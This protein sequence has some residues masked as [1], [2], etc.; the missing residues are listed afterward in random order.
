MTPWVKRTEFTAYMVTV[1]SVAAAAQ[2]SGAARSAMFVLDND[3]IA[4]RGAGRP[5]DYDY[6]QGSTMALSWAGAPQRVRQFAGGL[7]GCATAGARRVACVASGLA[8]RQQIYTPRR[9]AATPVPGER[10]YAGWLSASAV[11]HRVA[12][13]RI[14]SLEAEVGVSGPPSLAE[15]VQ[16]GVHR[17]LR[18]EAQ[19]GWAHQLR[20]APGLVVRYGDTRRTEWEVAR[21]ATVAAT[22]RLG[23]ALGTVVTGLSAGSDVTLG[24]RAGDGALPWNPAEPEIERPPRLYVRAGYRQEI[25]LRDVFVEGRGSS[26]RAALRTLVGQFEGALGYRRHRV[27]FEYR[28]VVR[29]RAYDAQPVAHAYGSF[30]LVVHSF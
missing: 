16:D 30:A 26:G 21:S 5:P 18:N 3:L 19:L 8:I 24:L 28:H 13:G 23:A 15:R 2:P 20:T 7:P 17:L 1:L 27:A 6:T 4:V 14:R 12:P 22:A 10:P 25:V 9:D 11:A 29:G